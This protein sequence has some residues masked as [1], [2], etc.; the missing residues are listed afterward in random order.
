VTAFHITRS[1]F[2]NGMALHIWAFLNRID[3]FARV[4]AVLARVF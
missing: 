1:I 3:F 2:L 4:N